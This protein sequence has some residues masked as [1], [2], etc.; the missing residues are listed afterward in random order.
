MILLRKLTLENFLSHPLTEISFDNNEKLLVDGIS[1]SGKSALLEAIV[2]CLYGKGRVENRSLVLRGKKTATVTLEVTDGDITYQI[3]RGTTNK[4]K[5]TLLINILEDGK[6]KS[7][8]RMGLRDQQDWIENS[9]LHASYALFVNSIAYMQDNG[10]TFVKQTAARRKELL[11]EILRAGEYADL[12][13]KA[14]ERLNVEIKAQADLQGQ[15]RAEE[16]MLSSLRAN[17]KDINELTKSRDSLKEK[18]DGFDKLIAS[19]DFS[20]NQITALE[21]SLRE[22]EIEAN[23][24]PPQIASLNDLLKRIMQ[25]VEQVEKDEELKKDLTEKVKDLEDLESEYVQLKSQVEIGQMNAYKLQALLSNK[26][27]E[28]KYAQQI[29]DIEKQL[30]PL[31]GDS[32]KCPSGDDCPFTKPILGQIE[33]LESEVKKKKELQKEY[34]AEVEQYEKDIVELAAQQVSGETMGK[35]LALGNLIQAKKDQASLLKSITEKKQKPVDVINKEFAD[36]RSM[37]KAHQT[38][39][40]GINKT[41]ADIRTK[42]SQFGPVSVAELREQKRSFEHGQNNAR[43]MLS[44]IEADISTAKNNDKMIAE[45]EAIKLTVG[46]Q[47]SSA[48]AN[49]DALSAIKE[50]FSQRGI[51]AVVLDYVIPRLEERINEILAQLSEFRIRIETQRQNSTGDGMVEGLYLNI[52]NELGEE[53]DYDS[54]SGGQK[55]KITVAI[56]EALASLQK[57]GFRLFDE[58]FLSLD[59][60]STEEFTEVMDKL[61]SKFNQI[62]CIT[63]LRNV[64]DL[65]EDQILVVRKEGLSIIST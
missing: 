16:A 38:T 59:E 36:T 19:A 25:D 1:G 13:K 47:L 62:I 21:S 55:L 45:H 37:I 60:Q 58:V 42:I 61:Q 63:H 6:W 56:A 57:V 34:E 17:S 3:V 11:L 18:V 52:Y 33:F 40:D 46:S 35:Y 30:I 64:K 31:R 12:Y 28:P 50:A 51:P 14:G 5:N 39:L 22:A 65:F 29:A 9:L 49:L 44:E 23:S 54:Y 41:I 43:M 24:I 26:P 10:D 53:F 15:L 32:S 8:E 4:A 20:I 48:D 7:I 2:W 27:R